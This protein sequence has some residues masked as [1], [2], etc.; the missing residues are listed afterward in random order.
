MKQKRI[1]KKLVLNKKTVTDLS[2]ADM[3]SAQGGTIY[4]MIFQP[5]CYGCQTNEYTCLLRCITIG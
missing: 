1:E 5:S 3:N 4:S 2:K